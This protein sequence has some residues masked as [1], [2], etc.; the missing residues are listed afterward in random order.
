V[1][2]WN[3]RA[4]GQT[5][6]ALDNPA[7]ARYFWGTFAFFFAMQAQ[8][9]LRGYLV[10]DLTHDALSL[11]LISVTFAAPTLLLAPV[12]GVVAD[13]VDRRQI[14]IV[15][16]TV[17]LA[18]TALTTVLILTGAIAYWQLLAISLFSSSTMVFNMPARQAMVPALVGRERLMNAIA[19]TSG[20][21]NVCRIVA[22][23]MGGLLVALIGVGGG[24]VVTMSFTVL[25]V[26]LFIGVPS[27]G[28]AERSRRSFL[29]DMLD[30]VVYLREN[31]LLLILLVVGTTPMLLAMPHQNLLPVFAVDVWDVGPVGLGLLQ[32]LAGVGGLAGAAL[33]ANLGGVRRQGRLMTASLVLFGTFITLFALSPG[34]G[35]ALV[36]I[37][38]S[39]L[40]AMVGMTMNNTLIQTVIPDKMRGRVMS[41]MMMTFGITPLGTLPAG[42]IARE[43]GVRVA[44][45]GG[46]VLLILFSLALFFASRTYR[47]LDRRDPFGAGDSIR[48]LPQAVPAG[49]DAAGD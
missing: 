20:S 49:V 25:A 16:Q 33:A 10:Y 28:A 41:L 6:A 1:A 46:G 29:G 34:F 24:Y 3:P 23:A 18:L 11:G 19:L 21:M 9:L 47:R 36:L 48:P 27:P 35:P 45:A 43:Y 13:R 12:A 30:G 39:E 7:F 38:C 26:L 22:P 37:L 42:W 44:V 15:S 5:F 17:G 2:W 8:M 14:I 4:W 31:R 40:C 32:T